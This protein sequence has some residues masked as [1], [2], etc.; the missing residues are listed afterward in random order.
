MNLRAPAWS[1]DLARRSCT[2]QASSPDRQKRARVHARALLF[3]LRLFYEKCLYPRGDL[4]T[5]CDSLGTYDVL[6]HGFEN[7]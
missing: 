1:D 7:L 2:I 4:F 5:R 6:T 3:I